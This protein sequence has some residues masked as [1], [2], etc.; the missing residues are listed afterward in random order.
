ML[1]LLLKK[2]IRTKI[3]QA[4]LKISLC[5]NKSNRQR[6][7]ANYIYSIL[8]FKLKLN[9]AQSFVKLKNNSKKFKSMCKLLMSFS[10]WIKNK[11]KRNKAIGFSII[12]LKNTF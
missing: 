12:K 7:V 1:I 5:K 9:S 3:Q 11:I 4:F 6:L 8:K 2:K 10:I